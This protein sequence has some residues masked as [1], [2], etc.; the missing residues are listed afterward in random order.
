MSRGFSLTSSADLFLLKEGSLTLSQHTKYTG[1]MG[2]FFTTLY[3]YTLYH[4]N[5]SHLCCCL[6]LGIHLVEYYQSISFYASLH[7]RSVY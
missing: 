5:D 4:N 7:K 1:A 2:G 3:M 6:Q